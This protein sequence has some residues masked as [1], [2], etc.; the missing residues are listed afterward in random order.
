M[1]GKEDVRLRALEPADV[2][3]L[4]NWEN[5]MELWA[6]SNTLTPF[7]KSQL[8]KYIQHASLDIF[9]TK[10]LRLLIEQANADNT[11]SPAGMIDLFDFDPYHQRAGVGIMVHESFRNKGLAHQAL[12]IFIAYCFSHLG[13][14]Q[15]YCSISV[16]NKASLTLFEKSGF[17][18]VGIKKDWRKT[19]SGYIDE[20]LLQLINVSVPRPSAT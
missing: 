5:Q 12:E 6:V 7:S 2:D 19:P 9:Q 13:L 4:Y 16:D 18:L 3:L 14:H 17:G 20:A 15:L 10:Q 11:F 8:Q 1:I